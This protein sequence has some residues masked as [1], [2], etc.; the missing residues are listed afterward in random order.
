[1]GNFNRGDDRGGFKPRNREVSMH[2]AVCNECG[3]RCEVPFRPTGDKPVYCNSCFGKI[4]NSEDSG[5]NRGNRYPRRDFSR[6]A[7]SGNHYGSNRDNGNADVVRQLEEVNTKL[8]RLIRA[9]EKPAQ[10]AVPQRI[11]KGT[12][13]QAVKRAVN[14]KKK[15]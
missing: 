13:K 12:L 14:S 8:D 10:E 2:Q 1:M 11:V 9:I 7:P 3:Q 15:K 4:R 6:G 5:D